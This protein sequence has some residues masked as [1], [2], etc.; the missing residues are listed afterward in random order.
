MKVAVAGGGPA[1]LFVAML[2]KR[3]G[4]SDVCV[5]DRN[6]PHTTYGWG[7]VYW[8][9]LLDRLRRIDA[10]TAGAIRDASVR[11]ASQVLDLNGRRSEHA[12]RGGYSIG[13]QRLLEIL[14]ERA[15]HA[16]V[17]VHFDHELGP[18][19]EHVDADVVIAADGAGSRW[20]QARAD[21]F[22]TEI[23]EG[24]NKYIWLGTAKV[25]DGFTFALVRTD[26]GWIWF[27]GYAFDDGMSTCVVECPAT[28]WER[29]GF[30][31][32]DAD[33]AAVRLTDVFRGPLGGHALVNRNSSWCTFR[34]VTNTRWYDGNVVLA[35][36]AAHTTH[37]TIGSGT[38]LALEDAA[39]LARNLTHEARITPAF[40]AY[41]RERQAAIR[42]SVS[43]ARFS[44]RWFEE[45][46]RYIGLPDDQFF[47][48]L[49]ERRSPLLARI[50]PRAYYRLHR[51]SERSA[52]LAHLRNWAGP[53]A[54]AAY[55]R[56]FG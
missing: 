13:R 5:F 28:T 49:R 22:G 15:V 37:F 6:A 18:D 4:T 14:A 2:L 32:M 8:D 19:L 17:R 1:G 53:R 3:H 25:F 46:E 23:V 7:V 10:S 43:E 51:A 12:S 41:E 20:R 36:D 30:E 26:A 56:R 52:W 38:R 40:A 55:S 9:D 35:G 29:L 31:T 50:P 27:H 34:T 42:Q 45:I 44:A 24:S 54:R 16:G 39:A 48:L 33:A 11:W 47:T 21:C